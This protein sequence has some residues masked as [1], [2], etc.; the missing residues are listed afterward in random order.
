MTLRELRQKHAKNL[1]RIRSLNKLVE[2]E[3]RDFSDSEN[4]ELEKLYSETKSLKEKIEQRE[5]VKELE[6]AVENSKQ[7]CETEKRKYS[8]SNALEILIEHK[9]KD[10]DLGFEKEV[11][12]ELRNL[13]VLH[14]GK[15]VFIPSKEPRLIFIKVRLNNTSI[16]GCMCLLTVILLYSI[17]FLLNRK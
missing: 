1:E 16:Y 10:F 6:L 4:Q 5:K 15:R 13:N 12:Q 2:K 8:F 11:D 3:E 14:E 7:P 9:G 17:F